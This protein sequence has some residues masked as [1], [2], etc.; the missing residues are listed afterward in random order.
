MSRPSGILAEGLPEGSIESNL[1]YNIF[2]WFFWGPGGSG[3]K[4]SYICWQH[5]YILWE[6]NPWMP[7][8]KKKL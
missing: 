2:D 6:K 5:F 8:E 7:A 4:V 3:Y 1:L